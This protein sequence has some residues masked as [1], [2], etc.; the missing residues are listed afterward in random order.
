MSTLSPAAT[1]IAITAPTN[2]SAVPPIKLASSTAPGL[3]W[4]GLSMIRGAIT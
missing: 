4:I 3:S 1:G 2:P